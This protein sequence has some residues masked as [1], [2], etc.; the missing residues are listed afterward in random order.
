MS[1]FHCPLEHLNQRILVT[2]KNK[3]ML[4]KTIALVK[5]ME[6]VVE[7]KLKLFEIKGME[8]GLK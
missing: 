2:R 7:A 3:V 5:V 6:M 8:L 4:G 1:Y